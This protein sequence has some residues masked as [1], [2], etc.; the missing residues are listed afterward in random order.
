MSL[1]FCLAFFPQA[2]ALIV[3]FLASQLG[4]YRQG[5]GTLDPR[6][7]AYLPPCVDRRC[8]CCCPRC[9]HVEALKKVSFAKCTYTIYSPGQRKTRHRFFICPNR[10]DQVVH[11]RRHSGVELPC[12]WSDIP[13]PSLSYETWTFCQYGKLVDGDLCGWLCSRYL[14]IG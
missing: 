10:P 3:S 1:F 2:Q 11:N 14:Q 9:C 4:Q 8:P 6:F 7:D 12:V 13:I 5:L